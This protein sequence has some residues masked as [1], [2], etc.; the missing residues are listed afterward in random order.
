LPQTPSHDQETVTLIKK[1][2]ICYIECKRLSLVV[3][4]L[5]FEEAYEKFCEKR[6]EIYQN[7]SNIESNLDAQPLSKDQSLGTFI[8]KTIVV[9]VSI[10]FVATTINYSARAFLDTLLPRITENTRV[11]TRNL[12]TDF[13]LNGLGRFF[14]THDL[15]RKTKKRYIKY[16]KFI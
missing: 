4:G 11:L 6:I 8:K 9:S 7:F 15:S 13:G 2:N 12:I 16:Q 10:I 5:S 14:I 3:S 1:D